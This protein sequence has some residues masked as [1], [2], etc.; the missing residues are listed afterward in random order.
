MSDLLINLAVG[1]WSTV[2]LGVCLALAAAF[3]ANHLQSWW[4]AARSWP[5]RIRATRTR[6]ANHRLIKESPVSEQSEY[7]GKHRFRT[8]LTGQ[9]PLV[10]QVSLPLD[11]TTV[12]VDGEL[13]ER[14]ELESAVA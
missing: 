9:Y 13:V 4:D 1:L 6:I 12:V 11:P 8:G 3:A 5:R 10:P 14:R 2:C 7:E